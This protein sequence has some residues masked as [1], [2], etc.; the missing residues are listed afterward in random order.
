MEL[1][2]WHAFVTAR[3]RASTKNEVKAAVM[4]LLNMHWQRGNHIRQVMSGNISGND[5]RRR[6]DD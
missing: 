6:L 1:H 5:N 3:E 2:P 4:Q